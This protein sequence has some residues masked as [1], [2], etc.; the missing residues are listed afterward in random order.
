MRRPCRFH[1]LIVYLSSAASTEIKMPWISSMSQRLRTHVEHCSNCHPSALGFHH[2]QIRSLCLFMMM[3]GRTVPI[4]NDYVW[5]RGHDDCNLFAV[6]I[7]WYLVLAE[8]LYE[9]TGQYF[10]FNACLSTACVAI[11]SVSDAIRKVVFDL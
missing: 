8:T 2:L 6:A 1:F 4:A 3:Q 9:H 11:T 7:C 5:R 10:Q